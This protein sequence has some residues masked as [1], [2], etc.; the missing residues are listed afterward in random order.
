[1]HILYNANV[2]TL[3]NDLPPATAIAIDGCRIAAVG[4]EKSILDTAT[5]Q[6]K[7]ENMGGKT[8]LPG[9][10]DSHIHLLQYALS[11]EK[12]DCAFKSKAECLNLISKVAQSL[13]E[14][15]WLLGHGWNQND[16]AGELGTA[17]DLDVVTLGHPA[18]L[19]S[20]SLH[21]AW[22]NTAA[23]R[24][25]NIN[26]TTPDLPG[27]RIER[28]FHGDPTGILFDN[29]CLLIEKIIPHPTACEAAKLISQAQQNLL[30]LGITSVHDFDDPICY[31]GLKILQKDNDLFLRVLKNF[32][33]INW[34]KPFAELPPTG[35]GN[36]HL[37]TGALKLFADGALGSRTAAMFQPYDDDPTN[38]GILVNDRQTLFEISSNA[39]QHHIALAIH[40][41]GDRANHEV[42]E[43]YKMLRNFEK[44]EKM[45][46]FRLR[47]EHVQCI[48]PE[49]LDQFNDLD[50]VASIQPVH[51]VSDARMAQ[52]AWGSRTKNSYPLR[53]ISKRHIPMIFG[54]DAPVEN[55]NPFHAIHA[56]MTRKDPLHSGVE[57]FHPEQAVPLSDCLNAYCTTPHTVNSKTIHL[58]LLDR[59]YYADLIVL[60]QNPFASDPDTLYNM[61][62]LACMID[63]KWVWQR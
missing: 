37:Q 41:I 24:L 12:I 47:V 17:A 18:F 30:E 21:S 29:A 50:I 48:Q 38:A 3:D 52:R 11:L 46:H 57:P 15:K 14:G 4:D 22:V 26:Q 59:N 39:V 5:S 35:L 62:V 1:M 42:I 58:G 45:P 36:D 33:L 8:I 6:T 13:P 61:K 27:G 25:A 43:S 51:A 31:E 2:L 20:K 10:T 56:A 60:D 28:D 40:A 32:P 19:T 53:A 16:W 23:L 34:T 44:S 49:D 54:S 55:P 63:G 7:K 9:F